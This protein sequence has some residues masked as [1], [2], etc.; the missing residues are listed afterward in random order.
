V[1]KLAKLVIIAASAVVLLGAALVFLLQNPAEVTDGTIVLCDREPTDIQKLTVTNGYGSYEVNAEGE[2]YTVH[3]IPA[4]LVD[5]E[6]F[7]ALMTNS[8]KVS[9]VRTADK[10]LQDPAVFGLDTPEAD[11]RVGYRDGTAL[12]LSVGDKE[13]VTGNYYVRVNGEKTVYLMESAACKGFLEPAKAYIEDTA[14]PEL[15]LSSPLSA[16]LDVTFTGGEN[17]IIRS[18]S[19]RYSRAAR[20]SKGRRYPSEPP[21]ISSEAKEH[22][23]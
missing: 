23:N 6:E 20:R 19:N 1:S 4:P 21:R 10:G 7:Y 14:T 16:I 22:M 11:V 12:T 2:G 5:I 13:R 17:L 15:A 3:D 8:A 18:K 9:A